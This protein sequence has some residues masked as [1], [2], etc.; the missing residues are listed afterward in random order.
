LAQQDPDAKIVLLT[1]GRSTE[2]DARR[3]GARGFLEKPF[4][5][6]ELGQMIRNLSV[7]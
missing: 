2:D 5:I 6:F 4:D 1:G 3:A 7:A